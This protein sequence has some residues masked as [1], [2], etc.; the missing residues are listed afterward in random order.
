MA[1][2]TTRPRKNSTGEKYSTRQ[3]VLELYFL[4]AQKILRRKAI[5]VAAEVPSAE[6][7]KD[8][9][10]A[11]AKVNCD[12]ICTSAIIV[13][14]LE[15]LPDSTE[16]V[17]FMTQDGVTGK[18]QASRSAYS[19]NTAAICLATV[20]GYTDG[21]GL[22]Q[23]NTFISFM[24][25]NTTIAGVNVGEQKFHAALPEAVAIIFFLVGT[26]LGHWI[27]VGKY[28]H[29]HR[30]VLLTSAAF[31]AAFVVLNLRVAFIAELGIALLSASMG[32]MNPAVGRIGAEPVNL[33]FITGALDKVG[34]H[35]A[36]A[37]RSTTPLDAQGSWDTHLRRAWV[38]GGLWL[39]FCA[40]AVFAGLVTKRMAGLELIPAVCILLFFALLARDH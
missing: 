7:Q 38:E 8:G 6:A 28:R 2:G 12:G 5:V 18:T 25:G 34:G 23:F 27:L 32:I 11:R 14:N 37:A 39:A 13:A 31:M 26:F 33:T 4:R 40:G 36:M 10:L 35:L 24:S 21:Y 3:P 30:I 17:T 16:W 22:R 29:S 9:A 15:Q 1:H 19:L 20:A